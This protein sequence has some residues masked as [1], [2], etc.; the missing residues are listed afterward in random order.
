MLSYWTVEFVRLKRSVRFEK[1][2]LLSVVLDI[3]RILNSALDCECLRWARQSFLCI[4]RMGFF[5]GPFSQLSDIFD[6][7]AH[8]YCDDL[9]RAWQ[10]FL[11]RQ[12]PVGYFCGPFSQLS[13]TVLC[14]KNVSWFENLW[15]EIRKE[16]KQLFLLMLK[17]KVSQELDVHLS[18]L[19]YVAMSKRLE[20]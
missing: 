12:W 14:C 2:Q 4:G 15:K 7:C 6:P 1:Q 20:I 11:C 17:F 10:S 9:R 5:Y 13:A 8:W 19:F 18:V 16:L 3:S